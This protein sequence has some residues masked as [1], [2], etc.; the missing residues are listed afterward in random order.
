M[1]KSTI[2]DVKNS[3]KTVQ[4]AKAEELDKA[5]ANLDRAI[6]AVPN[7]ATLKQASTSIAP[8]VAAVEAAEAQMQSGLSC[9]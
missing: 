3:A 1:V 5:Y 8:H 2:A 4:N 9:P 7:T 6:G